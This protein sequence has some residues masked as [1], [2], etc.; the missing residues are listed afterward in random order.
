MAE[1]KGNEYLSVEEWAEQRTE[2]LFPTIG[3]ETWE[4]PWGILHPA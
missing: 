1:P 3:E 4:Q 2:A